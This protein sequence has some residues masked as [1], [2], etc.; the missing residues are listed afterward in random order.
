[1]KRFLK[2]I[3][4]FKVIEYISYFKNFKHN[5]YSISQP[6]NP[7]RN[8]SDLFIWSSQFDRIDFIA[9]NIRALLLGKEVE[10]LH[11]FNFYDSDG[12]FLCHQE[13]KT[14]KYFERIKFDPIYSNSKY[15]S[16]IHY[17]ESKISLHEIFKN[18]GIQNKNDYCEQNRGYTIYY[19]KN[20]NL[21]NAVHGNFGGISKSG[22]KMAITNFQKH[23]YTPIYKFEKHSNY[24]V[25]F[26]NPTIREIE[27]GIHF[28]NKKVINKLKIP[29]LG[30]RFVSIK[31]YSGSISFES[32][33]P[34][35]R[36]ILFVNPYPNESYNFDV[37]HT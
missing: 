32:K 37:F 23:I 34:I 2:K 30:T 20:G 15:L 9:E 11:N 14:K 29:S 31:E 25:V 12:K 4:P 17:V 13:Y 33:L 10:V 22:T 26:N 35:C 3:L 27:I 18:K 7:E 21:G 28:N 36:A 16:F 5:V 1:M 8:L 6:I 24:D 19:P